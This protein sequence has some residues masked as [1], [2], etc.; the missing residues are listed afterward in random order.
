MLSV[1]LYGRNDDHGYNYHKRLAISI[2]CIAEMLSHPDDEIIYSDYNSPDD[3]PT[4]LEAIEDTLTKKAKS[5]IK[6]IRI[7]PSIHSR[8]Q[9]KTKLQVLEPIARNAAVRRSSPANKWIL[10]TNSDMIFVPKEGTETLSTLVSTLEDGFYSLPRFELPEQLWESSLDRADPQGNISLLKTDYKKLHLNSIV[11]MPGFL[12]FDNPGDF[13]LMLREDL[14]RIG[15]FDESMIL[16][17][18]VDANICKRMTLLRGQG[19]SLEE[20]LLGFHCNHTRKKTIAHDPFWKKNSWKRFV[21][22]KNL[23][24]ELNQPNWGLK[25]DILEQGSLSSKKTTIHLKALESTLRE[26]PEGAYDFLLNNSSYNTLTYTPSRIF[27]FLADQMFHLPENAVIAY[28]GYNPKIPL[29]LNQ[30]FSLL[31]SSKKVLTFPD[32]SILHQAS[33][34]IF[35]FGVDPTSQSKN[36]KHPN[37]LLQPFFKMKKKKKLQKVIGININHTIFKF[38]FLSQ[39]SPFLNSY[40]TGIVCGHWNSLLR[41]IPLF[42]IYVLKKHTPFLSR[43]LRTRVE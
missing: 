19:K 4:C 2:N 20:K 43:F 16:G 33:V 13:Q 28:F 34:L 24:T 14:F 5:L 7:R 37:D 17:W 36:E 30:Y 40:T 15:G 22:R 18:N 27:P 1:I 21:S 6:I 23:P 25:N 35:D 31:H 12:Q 11:R 29:L 42:I 10:S 3:F 26:A 38:A 32:Q 39:V 8:Y 41:S 9:K